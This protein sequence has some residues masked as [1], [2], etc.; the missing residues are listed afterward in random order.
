MQHRSMRTNKD[1]S[2]FE[3]DSLLQRIENSRPARL[4]D[5]MTLMF[6]GYFDKSINDIDLV[7]VETYLSKT[8]LKKRREIKP[9]LDR[10]SEI[11]HT[12]NLSNFV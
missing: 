3:V 11:L 4:G 12:V 10:V 5:Y 2:T 9:Q 7:E 8:S 6:L 1:R